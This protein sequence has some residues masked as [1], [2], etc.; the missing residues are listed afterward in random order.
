MEQICYQQKVGKCVVAE[1]YLGSNIRQTEFESTW[2][3]LSVIYWKRTKL[4]VSCTVSRFG[5]TRKSYSMNAT[6]LREITFGHLK[7]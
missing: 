3:G 1:I 2:W 5:E 7:I 6:F 4:H